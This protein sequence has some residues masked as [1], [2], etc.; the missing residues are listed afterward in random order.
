MSMAEARWVLRAA[1]QGWHVR[2]ESQQVFARLVSPQ[3]SLRDVAQALQV[4][5]RFHAAVEPRLLRHFDAVAA[6]PYQP[7]LPCLCAD[8]L[9]LG[10]EVPVLE[11]SRAEVCAE[12]AWGYRYVVEG[13]ML[14]GAVISRHLHKHLPNAKTV[15]YYSDVVPGSWPAF[16]GQMEVALATDAARRLASDAACQAFELLCEGCA[17]F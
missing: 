8:V 7:R 12:A 5:S 15:R 6:L 9:A 4:L 14:G 3:V 13:S 10:G 17:A 2:V 1:T 16:L 11:N